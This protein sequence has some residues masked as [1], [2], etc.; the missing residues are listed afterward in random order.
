MRYKPRIGYYFF[1][2]SLISVVTGW[3]AFAIFLFIDQVTIPSNDGIYW[4]FNLFWRDFLI[5]NV[6]TL[7]PIL[8]GGGFLGF[9][10]HHEYMRIGLSVKRAF[11]FG[12]VLGFLIVF[13]ICLFVWAIVIYIALLR[14]EVVPAIFLIRT[15]I[16]LSLGYGTGGLVSIIMYSFLSSDKSIIAFNLPKPNE[17]KTTETQQ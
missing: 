2:G 5:G 16:V 6:V 15:I 7:F 12:S 4:D 11:L 17:S 1:L 9:L 13:A 3:I 10:L 8:L 14:G